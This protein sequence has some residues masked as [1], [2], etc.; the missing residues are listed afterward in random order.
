MVYQCK[1]DELFCFSIAAIN[2]FSLMHQ[3]DPRTRNRGK[4]RKA[5]GNDEQA[6]DNSESN[7]FEARK[8]SEVSC[9]LE[10]TSWYYLYS[11]QYLVLENFIMTN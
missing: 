9:R 2:V 10:H 6:E 11:F 8:K 3:Q 4:K 7:V 1:E 5:P